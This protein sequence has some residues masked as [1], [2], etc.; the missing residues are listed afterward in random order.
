M[1]HPS[2]ASTHLIRPAEPR[3]VPAI[4]GL[5]TALADYE[6]LTHLLE[7]TVDKLEP[8]LFGDRPAAQ[9]LVA[10]VLVAA[11]APAR[12]V[13]PAGTSAGT[14]A[15][16]ALYFSN[17]ST[18]LAKPGI[19]LEDLFVLPAYRGTGLG[20][21]LLARLAEIAVERGCGRLEWSVLDW[22]QPAIDFYQGLGARVMPEW[23]IC[24][25]TGEALRGFGR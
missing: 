16:F 3:D 14:I 5:I 24:R 13:T 8:H 22:N 25:V 15:G 19:Y 4:V 23:R 6:Q 20:R 7:V 17:Y 11:E 21:A 9:C 2:D 10:E 1:T 18:F 12:D